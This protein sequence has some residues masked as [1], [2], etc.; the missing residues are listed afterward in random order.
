MVSVRRRIRT[1]FI[2]F[3][4][5][6][7]MVSAG[8]GAAQAS[9]ALPAIDGQSLCAAH[10][11]ATETRYGIPPHLLDAISIAESGRWDGARHASVAWPWTVSSGGDGKYF[12]TKG[13]A[14]AEVRRLKAAGV[15]NIDVGCMQVNLMYHPEAF[16]S[17]EEAFDPPSNV[18]YAARFLK[19]LYEAT[20]HWMTAA[21]Y[22]HSQTPSLAAEYRHKLEKIWDNMAGTEVAMASRPATPPQA[23]KPSLSGK[24]D[25][26]RAAWKSR[27]ADMESESRRIADAYRQAQLAEYMLRRQKMIDARQQPQRI[28]RLP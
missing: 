17:L 16:A 3:L 13:E 14:I 10:T 15:R 26:M 5:I 20:N 1:A 6:G 21:A 25:D 23:P 9:P 4:A 28:S 22:Y 19:G 2:A 7:I 8:N 12:P 24:V 18:A 11:Q 27:S